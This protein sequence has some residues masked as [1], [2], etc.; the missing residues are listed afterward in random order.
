[1]N[2][3]YLFKKLEK[4]N[5]QKAYWIDMCR[6]NMLSMFDFPI[7]AGLMGGVIGMFISK[8]NPTW[9]IICFSGW[10]MLFVSIIASSL[11]NEQF[12]NKLERELNNE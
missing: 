10:G 1:M 5:Q 4:K 9:S 7:W 6:R 12:K 11:I 2:Y 3:K 8:I